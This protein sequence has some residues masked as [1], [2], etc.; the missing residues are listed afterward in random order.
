MLRPIAYASSLFAEHRIVSHNRIRG[1][2]CE[3]VFCLSNPSK[4]DP[5]E[6]ARGGVVQTKVGAVFHHIQ[7]V[8]EFP[9]KR[10]I[11]SIV[12]LALIVIHAFKGVSVADAGWPS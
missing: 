12:H 9:Y 8:T 5:S 4:K 6:I 3:R 2:V 7:G 1:S 11:C 10:G